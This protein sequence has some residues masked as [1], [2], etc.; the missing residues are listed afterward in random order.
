MRFMAAP[1]FFNAS[2]KY[3]LQVESD[4]RSD[5]HHAFAVA[6]SIEIQ[7]DH[8]ELVFS[9][10]RAVEELQKGIRSIRN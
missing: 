10:A 8:A 5:K 3:Q 9:R 7:V 1:S 4:L 2:A 6:Q